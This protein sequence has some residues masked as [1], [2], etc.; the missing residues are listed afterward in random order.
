MTGDSEGTCGGILVKLLH[1]RLNH[2]VMKW[3]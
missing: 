2:S 1:I 3:L